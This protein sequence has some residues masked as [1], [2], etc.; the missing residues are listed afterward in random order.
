MYPAVKLSET[1]STEPAPGKTPAKSPWEERMDE[2][3]ANLKK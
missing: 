3:R 2:I 1:L